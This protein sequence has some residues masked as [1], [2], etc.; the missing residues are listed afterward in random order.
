MTMPPQSPRARLRQIRD[1]KLAMQ[2]LAR[3]LDAERDRLIRK[4]LE[5]GASQRD[6][7]VDTGLSKSTVA[8]KAPGDRADS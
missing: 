2:D 8:E 4:A 5:E 1:L 3:E 7:V 6:L